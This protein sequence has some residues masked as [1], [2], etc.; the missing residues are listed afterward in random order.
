MYFLKNILLYSGA[1]FTQTKYIVMITKEVFTKIIH[2]MTPGS[3]VLVLVGG[4][5]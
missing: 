1:W 4:H 2:F 5:I 3:E